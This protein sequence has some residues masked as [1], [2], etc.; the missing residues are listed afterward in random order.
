LSE[1]RLRKT[2]DVIARQVKHMTGLVDDL[3][4]VSRVT[5]GRVEI[6]RE[7]VDIRQA[8]NAAVEQVR[9]LIEKRLHQLNLAIDSGPLFVSGD[10]KRLVQV[11]A[12]LLNNAARYTP[13]GGLIEL[14]LE[15]QGHFIDIRITDNGIGMEPEL[16]ASAFDLFVQGKRTADR[17]QGGLGL[18]LAL[19]KSL[20]E[21]HEGSVQVFSSGPGQG[22]SFTVRLQRLANSHPD[23]NP[24]GQPLTPETDALHL[25][26]IDDNK[27]AAEMLVMFLQLMGH[28]VSNCNT[29][30]AG[31]EALAQQGFN[32]VLL[33]IGL[34]DMDGY[35]LAREIRRRMGPATPLLIA[36]S[37]YGQDKDREAAELAGIDHY[38]VKPVDT[39]Q[40]LELL[41]RQ[42]TAYPA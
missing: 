35:Q 42:T 13:E 25:L 12:N 15:N 10:E 26:V 1:D 40:L 29:P 24:S 33:D 9:P 7:P 17:A 36:I 8:V 39:E 5:Q 23:A 14:T 2:G 21:L 32:A 20:V 31:L 19:V 11:L 30:A 38:L 16:V 6:A 41:R 18:G 22:S 4:D 27:D 34:P 37:G 28:Q 3:L